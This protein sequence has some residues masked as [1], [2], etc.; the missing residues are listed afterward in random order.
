MCLGKNL[1]YSSCY[2]PTGNESLDQAEDIMLDMTC[3]RAELADG[4]HILELG[5]GW[6]SLSLFMAARFPNASVTGVSN[7]KT[8]KMFIDAK[9]A[10]RGIKNLTIITCDMNEFTI[11]QS[12]DRV[13]SVEM[14]E[15]MRNWDKLL[16]KVSDALKPQG[17]LFIHI[18]THRQ[19]GYLYNA[20][21]DSDFIGRYFFT[22]GIM[23]SDDLMLYFQD[24]LKIEDHWQVAG[25][26]Y[27]QTSNHWLLNMDEN[28]DKIL[29]LLKATYGEKEYVKW[30]HYWRIFYMACAELWN[31][32]NG[33]EWIVSHYRFVKR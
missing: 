11:D 12:F 8:Q 31:Y 4:Q 30:W 14:F 20:K 27:G 10:E 28:K 18:F 26:H 16:K 17:K 33:S 15:H 13:V 7:S 29:P 5:C 21:D 32:K 9:A 1:K 22:G 3:K 25:T 24:Y 19:Y 6:G 23:P 2:Y